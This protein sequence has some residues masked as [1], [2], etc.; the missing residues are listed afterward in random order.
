MPSNKD[1]MSPE[2]RRRILL[3]P[4]Q[5]PVTH[6]GS[7]KSHAGVTL[8]PETRSKRATSVDRLEITS[9]MTRGRFSVY[10]NPEEVN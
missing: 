5:L 2:E 9:R 4:I 3:A 10:Y 1:K 7:G 8:D 6:G